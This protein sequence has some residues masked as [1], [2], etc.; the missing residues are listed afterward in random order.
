MSTSDHPQRGKAPA[1]GCTASVRKSA[2]LATATAVVV[3]VLAVLA[4]K[5]LG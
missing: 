4:L 2:L 1:E 5:L 3:A